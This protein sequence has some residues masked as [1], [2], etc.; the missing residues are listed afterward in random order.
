MNP[1]D[2]SRFDKAVQALDKTGRTLHPHQ[3]EGINW[4]MQ[5][6]ANGTGG[7]LADDPGLGKTYQAL[8]L[9][10]TSPPA[11][12]T[13]VV[14]PTSILGQWQRVAQ[15]LLG[16]HAVYVHHGTRNRANFPMPRVVLTTYGVIRTEDTLADKRFD[17][18]IL[19]EIHEIKSRRS[20]I[21]KAVMRLQAPLR[22]GLS[23]T[24]VQ[25]TAEE[26]TNLFRFVLGLPSDTTQKINVQEMIKKLLLRRRKDI[27]QDKIPELDIETIPVPFHTEKES[28]FYFKVQNNVRREWE[29]LQE[30]GGSA[31]AENVA[32]FELLL[33][34]RQVSQ[35]PQLVLN[36]FKRKFK[37]DLGRWTDPS[38]KHLA[39]LDMIK[40]HPEEGT[41]IFCQF[42]EEM[43]LLEQLIEERGLQTLRLDGKM[44]NSERQDM[45]RQCES[46]FQPDSSV[47]SVNGITIPLHI[48]KHIKGFLTPPIT[49]IQIKAGGVGLNLQAFSRVYLLSPDWNPCNEIQAMAR[50]HRLGQ[51]RKVF[52]KRLVLEAPEGTS[53]I[54]DRIIGVQERKRNLMADLL[55][56]EQLRDNGRRRGKIGLNAQDYNRL[57][58]A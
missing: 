56:E 19:D 32:M 49:L 12:T 20:K 11:T 44:S 22:W 55:D 23:G 50:A 40:T 57:L 36:G 47:E 41:L 51:T 54:D 1:T 3:C 4:M 46:C 42:T 10:V 38:S 53:I 14:L 24:P 28:K 5:R 33:R 26:T 13:L 35:H 43:D 25:N 30:L 58:S 34:L 16:Q 2:T 18:I 8:S 17:R 6:E 29:S 39:L 45:L 9:V 52:V 21:S 48:M 31:G 15:E 37:K 27:L 7:L